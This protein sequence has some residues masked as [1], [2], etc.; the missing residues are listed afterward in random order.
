MR[1]MLV[2]PSG[3]GKTMLLTNMILDIYKECFSRI[4]IWSPS[5]EVDDTW[6]LVKDCIR[7]HIK[8]NDR[9]NYYFESYDPAELE[10]VINTQTIIDYQKEQKHKYLYQVLIVIDDFADDTNFTRKSQL[11]HSRTC[12]A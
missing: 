9:E 1:S 2:G 12:L 7:D 11:L 10:Q 8:P 3:S 5:I 6:K 4:Y